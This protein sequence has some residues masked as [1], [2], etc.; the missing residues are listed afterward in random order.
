MYAPARR[1][2]AVRDFLAEGFFRA[3]GDWQIVLVHGALKQKVAGIT[4]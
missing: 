2:E 3:N 1:A 4:Q